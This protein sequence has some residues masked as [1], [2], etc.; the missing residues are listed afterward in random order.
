MT[1]ILPPPPPPPP[2][3]GSQ[4]ANTATLVT[5]S[6]DIANLARGANIEGVVLALPAKNQI[7]VQTVFGTIVLQTTAK[8][9]LNSVITLT[10]S[11]LQPQPVL[12]VTGLNGAPFQG[13]GSPQSANPLFGQLAGQATNSANPTSAST[14]ATH[15]TL[16]VGTATSATLLRPAIANTQPA[17]SA[18]GPAGNAGAQTP[19]NQTGQAQPQNT[20]I[21]GTPGKVGNTP[22]ANAQANPNQTTTPPSASSGAVN[23]GINAK[24]TSQPTPIAAGGAKT[25]D[26]SAVTP[27]GNPNPSTSAPMLSQG[28]D[29]KA[30]NTTIPSGAR[31]PANIIKIEAPTGSALTP[32]T[33]P[34]GVL[35]LS[36]GSVMTGVVTGTTASGQP[37]LQLPSA[38]ITLDA[39][40][41]I[42]IGSRITIEV[43]G[44]AR[45][46]K[47]PGAADA[48]MRAG[49]G[50]TFVKSNKWNSLNEAL[51]IIEIADPNRFQ[52]IMQNSIPQT[53]SKLSAQIL[54]FLSA[55]RGGD[56]KNWLGDSAVRLIER[57]RPNL[58]SR[59]G[60]EFQAMAKF[61]D[62]PNNGDWRMAMIPIQHDGMVERIRLYQR[63]P[64]DKKEKESDGKRF[65][66]DFYLSN[67]GHIQVDGLAKPDGSRVDLIIRTEKPLA[68]NAQI[69]IAQIYNEAAE[70]TGIAGGIA[71]Q[72]SPGNFVEFP[73][74]AVENNRDSLIV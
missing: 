35:M 38:T 20:N 56:L 7:Q 36:R 46:P 11:Q 31:F 45:M 2:S 26:G 1:T 62:A 25:A 69:E 47:Q 9:P 19:V 53:G 68:Q 64:K 37:I 51:K 15:P 55:L 13:S 8:I 60:G 63:Q 33:Q 48:M 34:S 28:A 52:Q 58:L 3:S 74:L 50:E 42:A 39:Q 43:S 61:A 29:A 49:M 21:A 54:F 59:L 57:E 4:P 24:G 44:D 67:L 73:P 23:A 16:S 5:P 70:L 27:R 22:N 66:L 18:T 10:L 30:Q 14:P 71:F 65:V 17:A 72:A 40:G 6:A 12:Q 32:G 41:K